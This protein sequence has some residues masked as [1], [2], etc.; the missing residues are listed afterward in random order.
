MNFG[1]AISTCFYKYGTFS[2]RA[3]R[4]EFW[5]FSLFQFGSWIAASMI[6][7]RFESSLGTELLAL[8]IFALYLP[9]LAVG[10]RRLHDIG[11]SG[12]WQLLMLTGI[13]YLWLVYWWVQLPAGANQYGEVLSPA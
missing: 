13:G 3:S 12:W 1:H 8:F 5:W 9:G 10:S 2:G 7:E 11:R 4:S 6:V